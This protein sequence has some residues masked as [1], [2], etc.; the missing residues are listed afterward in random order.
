MTLK[1]LLTAALALALSAGGLGFVQA[2]A[3]TVTGQVVC[4]GDSLTR[5]ENASAGLGTAT[6]TTYPAVLA[7]ILGPTWRVTNLGTGGWTLDLMTGE[8]PKK[9]D[10]LYDPMLTKNVLIIFAGTNDLGGSRAGAATTFG[11]LK[12]YCQ[13][14]KAAHPWRILV[15]TLPMAGYPRVY[16]ADFDTQAVQYGAMIR[17]NWRSFA[18]GLIDLQADFRLGVPG[19]ERNSQYFNSRDFTHLTDEGYA[20]VGKAAAAAVKRQRV[21]PQRVKPQRVK[22]L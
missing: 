2:Q 11:K 3:A 9:V 6:G 8:A 19:A 7:R 14:R 20:I 21:K 22:P 18:D 1:G 10:P 13:A 17:R 4:H 16:P 5:G 12:A 15:C